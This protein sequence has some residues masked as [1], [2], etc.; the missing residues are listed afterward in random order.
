LPTTIIQVSQTSLYL[1]LYL[2]LGSTVPWFGSSV[3]IRPRSVNYLG[4]V[5]LSRAPC[6]HNPAGPIDE[7]HV[8]L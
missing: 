5:P 1:Y 7:R 2:Y 6:M 8:F 3:S 4:W